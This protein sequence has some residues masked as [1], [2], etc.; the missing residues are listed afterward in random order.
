MTNDELQAAIKL[1][2]EALERGEIEERHSGGAWH[3]PGG[4]TLIAGSTRIQYRIKPKPL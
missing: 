3:E 1:I 4:D 2:E